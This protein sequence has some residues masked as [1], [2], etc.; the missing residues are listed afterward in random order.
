MRSLI[1][2]LAM[3]G[4]SAFC[5]AGL[6]FILNATGLVDPTTAYSKRYQKHKTS[7]KVGVIS[8][9][10][11]PPEGR[12]TLKLIK[13]GGPF[14]Y[15]KDGTTFQNREQRLPRVP[16]K[17]YKEY[18]VKTP[19]VRHRGAKRIVAGARG[20]YYYTDDHYNTF[21]RIKE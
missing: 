3:V 1:K 12:R 2:S 19:G 20:E 10:D 9:A 18:T 16:R 17:Y 7:R 14:P 21:K 13:K 4:V 6:T 15:R 8:V 11:L 5:L